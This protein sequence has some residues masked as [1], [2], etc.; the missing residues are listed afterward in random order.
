LRAR[1]GHR[2]RQGRDDRTGAGGACVHPR[3]AW[4][5][6]WLLG[7]RSHAYPLRRFDEAG[8]RSRTAGAEGHRRWPDWRRKPRGPELRRPR[9]R[10]CENRLSPAVQSKPPTGAPRRFQLSCS[11]GIS[12]LSLLRSP[13][14]SPRFLFLVALAISAL[15]SV[16]RAQEEST[17]PQP[18]ST[19]APAY[20][21]ALTDT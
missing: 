7:R 4:Q 18:L 11:S 9:P 5:T 8:E 15:T 1:L 16:S 14:M 17:N 13:M 20:P 3:A 2:H 21:E 10:G 19:P 12:P 6:L